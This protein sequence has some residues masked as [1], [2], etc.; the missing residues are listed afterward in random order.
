MN[1]DDNKAITALRSAMPDSLKAC[2]R[3]SPER[4]L[5][6]A[7]PS[8]GGGG[9]QF[10]PT[11]SLFHFLRLKPPQSTLSVLDPSNP[12]RGGA[13]GLRT[14]RATPNLSLDCPTYLSEQDDLV[15]SVV[16]RGAGRFVRA[17]AKPSSVQSSPSSR[18]SALEGRPTRQ[19]RGRESCGDVTPAQHPTLTL[20]RSIGV[21]L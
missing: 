16:G 17:M 8:R 5:S 12:Q 21:Q 2:D 9:F 10:G 18:D 19:R 7:A 3:D 14:R 1:R 15:K 11:A 4:R 13:T 20:L 6:E